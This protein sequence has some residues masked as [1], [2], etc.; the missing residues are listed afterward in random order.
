MLRLN[1]EAL[2]KEIHDIANQG[3]TSYIDAAVEYANKNDIDIEA[4][5]EIIRKHPNMK[6]RIQDEAED[7]LMMERTA[8]LPV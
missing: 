7:L 3:G 4:I 5:A 8:K 6:S 2:I 1:H